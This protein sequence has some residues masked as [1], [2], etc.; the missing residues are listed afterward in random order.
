MIIIMIIIIVITIMIMIIIIIII[1]NFI[2]RS[3]RSC[4]YV[5]S[6]REL[7]MPFSEIVSSV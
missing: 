6:G 3:G 2:R 4:K 7:N 5:T 1:T